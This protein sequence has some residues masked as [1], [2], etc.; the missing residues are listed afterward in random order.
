MHNIAIGYVCNTP[1]QPLA[2]HI[3]HPTQLH[4]TRFYD[5]LFKLTLLLH[6]NVWFYEKCDYTLNTFP[7]IPI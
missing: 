5:K 1:E 3:Y 2:K 6:A 7:E 4:G